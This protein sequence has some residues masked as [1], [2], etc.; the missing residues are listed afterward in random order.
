MATHLRVLSES[1]P[2]NTKMTIVYKNP[3]FRVLMIK[4]A[5]ALEG[6]NGFQNNMGFMSLEDAVYQS[7]ASV[8]NPNAYHISFSMS[9][10]LPS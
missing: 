4:V 10:C 5:L 8:K 2:M 3:Y 7:N 9:P 1:Y 6:L